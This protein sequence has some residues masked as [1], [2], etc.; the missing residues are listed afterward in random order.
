[1][2]TTSTLLLVP[3][4]SS[5]QLTIR[6]TDPEIRELAAK[7]RDAVAQATRTTESS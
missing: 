3:V 2:S 7:L 4:I 5:Q 1:M 6:L